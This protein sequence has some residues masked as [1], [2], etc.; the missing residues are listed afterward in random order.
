MRTKKLK[1]QREVK[2][3]SWKENEIVNKNQ[4][5]KTNRQHLRCFGVL[6]AS[7]ISW[8]E[9]FTVTLARNFE[10]DQPLAERDQWTII[11]F[12]W[13]FYSNIFVSRLHICILQK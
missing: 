13:Y 5:F 3:D 12:E 6:A 2:E 7:L 10:R 11:L 4:R 9:I 1:L 8:N